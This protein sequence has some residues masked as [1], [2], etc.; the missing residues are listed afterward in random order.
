MAGRETGVV[1]KR[2]LGDP[3]LAIRYIGPART[4]LGILKNDMAF[5][6]L[7]QGLR[8]ATIPIEEVIE[9]GPIRRPSSEAGSTDTGRNDRL[10]NPQGT[11]GEEE[12]TERRTRGHVHLYAM[13]NHGQDEVW[14]DARAVTVEEKTVK[15][16]LEYIPYLWV[17]MATEGGGNSPSFTSSGNRN[18]M[19]RQIGLHVFEPLTDEELAQ[20]RGS[21]DHDDG[22]HFYAGTMEARTVLEL[23]GDMQQFGHDM[24]ASTTSPNRINHSDD[25]LYYM[26]PGVAGKLAPDR[27]SDDARL[28]QQAVCLDPDDPKKTITHTGPYMYGNYTYGGYPLGGVEWQMKGKVRPGKYLVKSNAWFEFNCQEVAGPDFTAVIKVIVGKAPG[29]VTT[30]TVEVP[31]AQNM[32][33]YYPRDIYPQADGGSPAGPYYDFPG[34]NPHG[35]SWWQ[36]GIEVDVQIGTISV[37]DREEDVVMPPWGFVSSSART[38]KEICWCMRNYSTQYMGGVVRTG[39]GT[40]TN[41]HYESYGPGPCDCT[42]KS[43]SSRSRVSTA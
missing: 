31:F 35:P 21:E 11:S 43:R 17:G 13:S 7:D 18:D 19:F 5:N 3:E 32:W 14:I 37:K 9:S 4:L 1:R 6:R 39:I 34:P 15:G 41:F 27:E 22:Y 12:R 20:V 2:L 33:S 29:R 36:G 38:V 30:T 24:P 16:G 42:G 10:L 26:G 25:K 40:G 23:G 28:W 8:R